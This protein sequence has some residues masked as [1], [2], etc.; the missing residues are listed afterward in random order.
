MA[1]SDCLNWLWHQKVIKDFYDYF[2]GIVM[3]EIISFESG[4][5]HLAICVCLYIQTYMYDEGDEGDWGHWRLLPPRWV[6][7]L[8][9]YQQLVISEISIQRKKNTR[10]SLDPAQ[11][12]QASQISMYYL[13]WDY[14]QRKR[15][16]PPVHGWTWVVISKWNNQSSILSSL[17]C[18]V[19]GLSLATFYSLVALILYASS[20]TMPFL[21]QRYFKLKHFLVVLIKKKVSLLCIYIYIRKKKQEKCRKGKFE[22]G[23]KMNN[24]SL[25][26]HIHY[27]CIFII[28]FF[29]TLNK[30][31]G[32]MPFPNRVGFII[33]LY[34]KQQ[35][36]NSNL[37]HVVALLK[38]NPTGSGSHSILSK[39]KS[40]ASNKMQKWTG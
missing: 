35:F 11:N 14:S 10:N 19:R 20:I 1:N 4:Q 26:I 21:C 9:R 34:F 12:P 29:M 16:T 24:K 40:K 33:P 17:V 6:D 13:Q 32:V 18:S 27:K 5:G 28:S 30:E 2:L 31:I 8:S 38:I 22:R 25:H 3:D 37:K 15:W 7:G 36:L 39:N 23:T